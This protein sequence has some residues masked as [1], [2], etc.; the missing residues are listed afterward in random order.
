M[1]LNSNNQSKNVLIGFVGSDKA[2]IIHYI[3]RVLHQLKQ[4]VLLVDYCETRALSYSVPNVEEIALFDYRGIDV[5]SKTNIPFSN[6]NFVLID[7]GFHLT[8]SLLHSCNAIVIVSDLQIHNVKRLTPLKIKKGQARY[9]FIKDIV[10]GKIGSKY[11]CNQLS[12]LALNQLNCVEFYYD[13]KDLKTMLN[14]EYN[15]IFTFKRI[16]WE[17]KQAIV[18]LLSQY[19]E[20]KEINKSFKLAER[21][22]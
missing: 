21:G 7:F 12:H 3:S 1:L 9:L 17:Q 18:T 2:E 5:T 8:H 13:E 4:K 11:I 19:F 15:Q 22:K 10:K 20:I 6:Y 16:S 14:C